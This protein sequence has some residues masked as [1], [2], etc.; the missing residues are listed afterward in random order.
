MQFQ[1]FQL[2]D[3]ALQKGAILPKARIGY[4]TLGRLNAARDNVILAPTWFTGQPADVAGVMTGPGRAMDPAEYFI[5]IPNHLGGGLSSSP[6]NMSPPFEQTRFPRATTYDNAVAQHRL[7][8]EGLGVDKL[9]L[10]SSWSMGACQVYAFAALFPDMVQ[11]LAPIAGSARTGAFNKVFLNGIRQAVMGD[12]AWAGGWYGNRPPV[13][14]LRQ[15]GRIYAGWGF[16]EAFYRKEIYKAFGHHSLE[17]HIELFWEAFFLKCDANDL[18]AQMWTWYHNDLGDHPAFGGDFEKALG[19]ITAR[20]I[21]LPG[22]TDSYFPPHD[23]AYEVS[24]MPNAECRPV[25][26]DWGH[27]C[28]INGEDQAFIDTA[29][30]ELLG[31]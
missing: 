10:A 31:D 12:P 30:R 2:G 13:D 16:S 6:S 27:M 4:A 26:T 22:S 29:L 24:C 7:L 3:F 18:L 20:T 5:V 19:A 17:Q 23:N 15:I 25:P 1:T 8:T 21:V 11:A 14:G 28:P 9:R